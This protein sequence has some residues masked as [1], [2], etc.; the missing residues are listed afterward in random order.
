M[1]V[2]FQD[3]FAR[4]RAWRKLRETLASADLET[5]CVEVD[6]FWQQAPLSTHYLH[7]ADIDNW[8]TPWELIADNNYC[9]YGRALGMV[10]TLMLLGVKDIALVEVTAY[11][12]EDTV[13]IL[14]DNA[15]YVLNFLPNSVVNI[16]LSDFQ[17]KNQLNITNLYSKI[18]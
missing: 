8:P 6:K 7:P 9:Y 18:G 12:A 17:I 15:K 4:L 3:N 5:I 16:S 1:N 11:N 2:F 14:V 10:Y 13:L